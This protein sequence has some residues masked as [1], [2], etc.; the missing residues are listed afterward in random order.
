MKNPFVYLLTPP[1][2]PFIEYLEPLAGAGLKMLQYR[3]PGHTDTERFGELEQIRD[4]LDG[5][6]TRLIV[7]ERPDLAISVDADG[8]HLGDEDLPVESVKS[9]WPEFLVGRTRRA[10][11]VLDDRADYYGVGPVFS[12]FS[13]DL[14]VE[15]CGWSGIRNVLDRTNKE[16]FA[17]G[18]I[19]PSRLTEVPEGLAGICV[20]GAVWNR[21]EPVEAFRE[22]SDRLQES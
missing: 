5:F 2:R 12:S 17:I 20:I 21:A 18:G 10:D 11:E 1:D 22:L 3:R 8:V 19:D 7:N 6:P 15:P 13:K 4:R 14:A 9:E 16:V